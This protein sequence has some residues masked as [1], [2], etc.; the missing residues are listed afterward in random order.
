M[1]EALS[2][3]HVRACEFFRPVNFPGL[4]PAVVADTPVRLHGTPGKVRG[5]PPLLGE[6]SDAV[7]QSLGYSSDEIAELRAAGAL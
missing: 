4:P 2:D 1:A 5:R 6:H 3:P 7:L